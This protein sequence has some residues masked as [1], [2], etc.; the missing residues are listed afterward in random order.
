LKIIQSFWSLFFNIKK[1]QLQD[2]LNNC[3]I[4]PINNQIES[5]P[6][7]QHEKLIEFCQ[8]NDVAVSGYC[9]LGGQQS[10]YCKIN[11][12]LIIKNQ[13]NQIF[14]PKIRSKRAK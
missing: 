9:P 8:K 5:Y 14:I 1:S 2:V 13:N 6:Y 3:K 11:F 10:K 4:K 12:I 7:L